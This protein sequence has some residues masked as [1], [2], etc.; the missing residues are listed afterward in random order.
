MNNYINIFVKGGEIMKLVKPVE[1]ELKNVVAYNN[2]TCAHLDNGNCGC[3]KPFEW[4]KILPLICGP[5]N[6]VLV[7]TF[8]YTY[9]PGFKTP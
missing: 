9:G 6:P 2:E 3:N 8:C 5:Y 7:S 4:G 1:S